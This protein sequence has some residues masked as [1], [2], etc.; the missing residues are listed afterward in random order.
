MIVFM[1]LMDIDGNISVKTTLHIEY[2]DENKVGVNVQ[3]QGYEGKFGSQN[4]NKGD[5]NTDLMGYDINIYNRHK[6]KL[7]ISLAT[8]GEAKLDTGIGAG[9]GIMCLGI[10]PAMVKGTFGLE[11]EVNGSGQIDW[12]TVDGIKWRVDADASVRGY[13]QAKALVKLKVKT[14]G[15]FGSKEN[16]FEREFDLSDITIFEDKITKQVPDVEFKDDI[17]I[18]FDMDLNTLN[19]M[20][21]R[22]NPQYDPM[23]E[24]IEEYT[25]SNNGS[26]MDVIAE[27]VGD[28][29]IRLLVYGLKDGAG[30][31][32]EN[33]FSYTYGALRNEGIAYIHAGV[34]QIFHKL[35]EN[36]TAGEII[37]SLG[38]KGDFILD[39]DSFDAYVG[40]SFERNGYEY[41]M[42]F[43]NLYGMYDSV[44]NA[45]KLAVRDQKMLNNNVTVDVR[46]VD[47]FDDVNLYEYIKMEAG[48]W[49][50]AEMP[51][52]KPS[53]Q[54]P[55]GDTWTSVIQAGYGGVS[56]P[57]YGRN[58]LSF[59]CQ[60]VP[61]SVGTYTLV[62]DVSDDLIKRQISSGSERIVCSW[63]YDDGTNRQ[64][65]VQDQNG[66]VVPGVLYIRNA[67]LRYK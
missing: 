7:S 23:D 10:M 32:K 4:V 36:T 1:I 62:V 67:V 31:T 6:D 43:G 53:I 37:D 29:D 66:K 34:E 3:Q 59:E 17:P 47:N 49:P 46:R 52:K 14:D 63:Q 39:G 65:Y 54:M 55:S 50:G 38:L 8:E 26:Y 11:S 58:E 12:D 13:L 22:V 56:F 35:N 45:M 64:I 2:R 20:F 21:I 5:F 57:A 40:Y 44:T 18:Y 15:I 24:A 16:G 51:S 25:L 27:P 41:T 33:I 42:Y 48:Y 28:N 60:F 61:E 9:A 19:Q 30:G